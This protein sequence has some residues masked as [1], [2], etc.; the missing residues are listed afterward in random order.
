MR[1]R[2][3]DPRCREFWFSLA[4]NISLLVGAAYFFGG[5]PL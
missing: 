5:K 4:L 3:Y 2:Q 1:N